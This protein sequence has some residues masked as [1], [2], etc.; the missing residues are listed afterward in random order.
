MEDEHGTLRYW[1][2]FLC[3]E[4]TQFFE[5]DAF[6]CHTRQSH[7]QHINED[8]LTVLTIA[9]R[10]D[11]PQGI[12]SCPLCQWA[13]SQ[14]APIE[15]AELLKHIAED[16]H[17][18]S[19]RALP[20]APDDD[21]EADMNN[22]HILD[23]IQKVELWLS[24]VRPAVDVES[25]VS[26]TRR[27]SARDSD[28]YFLTNAYFADGASSN[29]SRSLQSQKS[30]GKDLSDLSE[31]IFEDEPFIYHPDSSST[32]NA[33]RALGNE[34]SKVLGENEIGLPVPE[35]HF[36]DWAY[37]T[38]LTTEKIELVLPEAS[39]KLVEYINDKAKKLFAITVLSNPT[40]LFHAM[41]AFRR[42]SVTDE[43]CLP[44]ERK[45]IS[46]GECDSLAEDSD[47]TDGCQ[48]KRRGQC[49]HDARLNVFHHKMWDWTSICT[50]YDRQWAFFLHHFRHETFTYAL[51]SRCILPFK[52]TIEKDSNIS[53]GHFSSVTQASMLA[54][55]QDFI[56]AVSIKP[57]PKLAL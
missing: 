24:L 15:R 37:S 7:K 26:P 12:T 9:C 32:V 48:S 1:I 43:E 52:K 31:L 44:I 19:L 28:P 51:H 23:G 11:S 50:F 55:C 46:L 49:K 30:R 45:F 39:P 34:I 40:E 13:E 53:P 42:H 41:E 2:C 57:F 16:M 22:K 35:P 14:E 20:W 56:K 18:F 8:Q 4:H 3:G 6:L 36:P 17:S 5:E 25:L 29:D 47:C 27:R 21:A 33:I 54:E 38:I 10:R